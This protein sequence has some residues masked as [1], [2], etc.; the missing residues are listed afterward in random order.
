MG[1]SL[2]EATS[3]VQPEFS[4]P[5]QFTHSKTGRHYRVFRKPGQLFIEESLADQSGRVVYSDPR[6]VRYA[7]GSGN[8]ARSFLVERPGRLYQAPIAFF[9]APGRWGRW[10]MSPGYDT[11]AYI[12]FTRRV[13]ANCLFCHAGR[14][15]TQNRAGDI[16][17][18]SRPFAETSIGCERCHSP[19]DRHVAQPG[20]AIVNPAKLSPDLRDQVCEQCHLF[21]AAR[22]TQP[23]KL[24]ADYQPGQSLGA[25]LA[26]YDYEDPDR[27]P[28]LTGH[29]QEMKQ[30]SCR[31]KSKNR[32]WCG[33][34]HDVHAKELPADRAGLYRTK[35]LHCHAPNACSRRPDPSSPAH[36]ENNCIA[37]HMPKRPVIES[38]HVTFTDHRI[39]RKP[40]ANFARQ[41][42]GT[43]LKLILPAEMDDPVTATRNLGF[44][45]ADLASSTGREEYHRKAVQTLLPLVGT[46]ITDSA[47]W[48]N[49]GEGHLA[50]G[51]VEQA[52]DA[53]RHAV[54]SDPGSASAHYSLAYLYQLRGRLSESIHEYRRALEADPYKAEAFGNLA[55][56]YAKIGEAKEAL[57][58]L[59][60]ALNLEPGNLQWRAMR[61]RVQS[62]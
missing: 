53:F 28:T 27:E 38:A 41:T 20:A 43:R 16:F 50:S 31:R 32:L 19:G 61:S 39:L 22:V 30:S 18:A 48:Q 12:G 33:S 4:K 60:E 17:Q 5:V 10:D 46:A 6:M 25:F 57:K 15:N 35:C 52:E 45:Y 2:A 24:F 55:A 62:R 23:G 40:N 11:E 1:R 44:A 7:I 47:F 58:A 49:L 59:D 8:H 56:A 36:R 54:A 51:E 3:A 9:K 37:C 21:G 14:V 26:I 29:P 13:T 42:V 34:C